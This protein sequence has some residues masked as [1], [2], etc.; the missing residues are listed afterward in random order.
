MLAVPQGLA[1]VELPPAPWL[2]RW[3][4]LSGPEHLSADLP[5][6]LTGIVVALAQLTWGAGLVLV[7]TAPR[8]W[9]PA[10]AFLGATGAVGLIITVGEGMSGW[11]DAFVRGQILRRVSLD[12][13]DPYMSIVHTLADVGLATSAWGALLAVTWLWIVPPGGLVEPPTPTAR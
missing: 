1:A 9:R 6:L 5:G 10:S 13:L 8:P 2:L 7:G 3:A 12:F 11:A 4:G